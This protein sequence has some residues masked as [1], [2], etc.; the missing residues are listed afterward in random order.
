MTKVVVLGPPGA[1]KGTQARVLA[2]RIGVPHLS[3]GSLLRSEIAAR[4]DPG[5]RVAATVGAGEL[6]D[7]D[8]IVAVLR[9]PLA[10]AEAGGWV[11]D[12]APRTG[13]QA[14]ALAEMIEG[15]GPSRAVVLALEVPDDE[16]RARL[17]QRA[18]LEHRADDTPVVISHRLSVWAREG[19]PL[20]T[21][22]ERRK[23]R[24][25]LDGRGTAEAVAS[26]AAT[27]VEAAGRANT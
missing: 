2:S 7:V 20:L 5:N 14:A 24:V 25:R 16:L 11:L 21:W 3:V 22:Y 26:R 6:V 27:A 18:S 9:D 23:M 10:A 8:D 17:V 1:G 15:P 12:G 13:Q 4:S 19:P